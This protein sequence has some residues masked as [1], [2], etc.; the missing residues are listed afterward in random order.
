MLFD[1]IALERHDYTATRAERLQ[2]AKH[3]ILRLNANVPQKPLRQ[4]P[5]FVDATKQQCLKCKTLTW[6]KH[7]SLLDRYVQN[8]NKDKEKIITSKEEETSITMSIAELDGGATE[9]HGETRR[10]RL[11]FQLRSGQLHNGKRV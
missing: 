9:S 1:R 8:I 2:N 6:H 10:Q 11:H 4:R 5:E 7:N 3:W